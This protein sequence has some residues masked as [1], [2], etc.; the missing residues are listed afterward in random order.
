M[1]AYGCVPAVQI[2]L[3]TGNQADAPQ[4]AQPVSASECPAYNDPSVTCRALT[5][6]EIRAL[7]QYVGRAAGFAMLAGAK[8]LEVHGHA[9]YLIDQFLN[10]EINKRTDEYCGT[11]ENRFRIVKEVREMTV[12]GG[13]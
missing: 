12:K 6:D 1:E 13:S 2:T 10:P 9:G 11:P 4:L 5:I 7:V 8:L 3:G